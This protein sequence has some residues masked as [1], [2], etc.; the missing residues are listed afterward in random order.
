MVTNRSATDRTSH[1]FKP[2]IFY[3]KI[4]IRYSN[5]SGA[6]SKLTMVDIASIIVAPKVLSEQ[7]QH[8]P[9]IPGK[10]TI[11]QPFRPSVASAGIGSPLPNTMQMIGT[12][13]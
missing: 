9:E 10:G 13:Y 7:H 6:E 12:Y 1:T 2:M 5:L 8:Q 11:P 3:Y 4:R